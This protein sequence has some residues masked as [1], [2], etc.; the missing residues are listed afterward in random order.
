MWVKTQDGRLFDGREFIL[1]SAGGGG[2]SD[3]TEI[4]AGGRLCGVYHNQVIAQVVLDMI[5]GYIAGGYE[6]LFVMP[7][8]DFMKPFEPIPGSINAARKLYGIPPTVPLPYSEYT[9]RMAR[10]CTLCK[11]KPGLRVNHGG[12]P[13]ACAKCSD[14]HSY[15]APIGVC[16]AGFKSYMAAGLPVLEE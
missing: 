15:W 6:T 13:M 3:K 7:G 14:A 5:E 2:G 4:R 8:K 12:D 16:G 11:N 9:K 1:T 10:P